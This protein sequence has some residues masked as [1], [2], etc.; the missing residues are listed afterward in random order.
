MKAR[1]DSVLLEVCVEENFSEVAEVAN[2][3]QMNLLSKKYL[4]SG[5]ICCCHLPSGRGDAQVVRGV[6]GPVRLHV[7]PVRK[8][9][10]H[11]NSIFVVE[12]DIV[13]SRSRNSWQRHDIARITIVRYR[14]A[15]LCLKEI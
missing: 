11:S 3:V 4:S 1:G 14:Y 6:Q 13:V 9:E 7:V 15:L 5:A 8:I 2:S 10:E 12:F